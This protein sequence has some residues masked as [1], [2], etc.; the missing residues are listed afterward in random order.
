MGVYFFMISRCFFFG[1]GAGYGHPWKD[2]GPLWPSGVYE[3]TPSKDVFG[4]DNQSPFQLP[5]PHNKWMVPFKKIKNKKLAIQ[6]SSCYRW[7]GGRAGCGDFDK[8][9]L[10]RGGILTALLP[11]ALSSYVIFTKHHCPRVRFLWGFDTFLEMSKSPPYTLSLPP[12]QNID[13]CI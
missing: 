7:G 1:G 4:G 11:L 10:T 2:V 12:G 9:H 6:A 13:R 3:V 8:L 5:P